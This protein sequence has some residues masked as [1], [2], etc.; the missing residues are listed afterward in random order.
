MSTDPE[1][2]LNTLAP[3]SAQPRPAGKLHA[4]RH[5][6]D[7]STPPHYATRIRAALG[8]HIGCDPASSGKEDNNVIRAKVYYTHDENGLDP[9]RG[10]LSPVYLNPP[11]VNRDEF[12]RRAAVEA[13][14]GVEMVVCLNL[15]HLCAAYAQ[16]LVC[17]AAALHIPR[18]RPAFLHGRTRQRSESPTDG[19]AFLYCGPQPQ[20]FI[21]EFAKDVGWTA[22]VYQTI[23]T[24]LKVQAEV[25]NGCLLQRD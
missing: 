18:G 25:K 1:S 3:T 10:W 8:G 23:I 9:R 6:D 14:R 4:Q 16:P 17:Q 5:A 13:A 15:K 2:L 12:L 7:Y 11:S 20:R 24:P 22:L 21:T 19:R